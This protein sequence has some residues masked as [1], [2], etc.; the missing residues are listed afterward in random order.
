[1]KVT[2]RNGNEITSAQVGDQLLLR[3]EILDEHSK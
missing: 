3:F 2:D 1:M